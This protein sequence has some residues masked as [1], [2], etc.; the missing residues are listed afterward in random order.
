VH[1][2]RRDFVRLLNTALAVQAKSGGRLER[3]VTAKHM[4]QFG[5]IHGEGAGLALNKWKF[6]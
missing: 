2:G 5:R 6:S 1:D 4:R 3:Q